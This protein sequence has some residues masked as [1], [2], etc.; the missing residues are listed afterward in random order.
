VLLF[1][2]VCP[3][4][5]L[6]IT[7]FFSSPAGW[8]FELLPSSRQVTALMVNPYLRGR[9]FPCRHF[10]TYRLYMHL[11][12]C[13]I[14]TLP[15]FPANGG[16]FFLRVCR[17]RPGRTLKLFCSNFCNC[18]RFFPRIFSL[19]LN[20]P[21]IFILSIT[22]SFNVYFCAKKCSLGENFFPRHSFS[23]VKS[24]LP[25]WN[26]EASGEVLGMG[27]NFSFFYRPFPR[28]VFPPSICN[29]IAL[30]HP[31]FLLS[32]QCAGRH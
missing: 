30:S 29:T 14:A 12:I 28:K 10:L 27:Q 11:V 9:F 4:V 7:F 26:Y 13:L 19:A 20:G 5:P 23:F 3:H 6:L 32:L 31:H 8:R 18:P 17:K 1:F 16:G 2:G 24:P 15:F 22:L 21:L 25:R